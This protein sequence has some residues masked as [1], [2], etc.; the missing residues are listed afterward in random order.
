MTVEELIEKEKLYHKRIEYWYKGCYVKA[1]K[2]NTHVFDDMLVDYWIF[3]VERNSYVIYMK[4]GGF[5]VT[6]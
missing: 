2:Y 5:N 6:I 4:D 3:N 1:G